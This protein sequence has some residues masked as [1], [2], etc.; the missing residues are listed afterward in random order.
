MLPPA[1]ACRVASPRRIAESPRLSIA[2]NAECLWSR[3]HETEADLTPGFGAVA[4][5]QPAKLAVDYFKPDRATGYLYQTSLDI[6]RQ[7]GKTYSVDIGYLGTFGHHLPSPTHENINQVPDNLLGPGNLQVKRPF[8][9]FSN[10]TLDSADIGNS[11]YNGVN[12]GLEKRYSQGLQFRANYTFSKFFDDLDAAS[13]LAAYPG[14][15]SFTDYYSPARLGVGS[16]ETTSA[17]GSSAAL[18]TICRSA[19]AA[20]GHPNHAG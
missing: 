14:T 2:R 6:Q 8:P 11:S 19:K 16:Q 1:L 13:E 5:G 12:V 10:V 7:L 18:F 3:S 17:I 4:V 20:A 9:Q 15:N